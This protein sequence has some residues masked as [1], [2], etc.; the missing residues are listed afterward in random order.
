VEQQAGIADEL[1]EE[2]VRHLERRG[3]GSYTMRSYR[4]GL[5]DFS[6]WLTRVGRELVEVSRRDVEAY[7]GEFAAGPGTAARGSGVVD[8]ATGQPVRVRR[9]ARTVNHRLSVLASFFAFLL[10]RDTELGGVWAGRVSPVPARAGELTHSMGGGGDAPPWRP[11][12]ELRRRE[13]RE[14]PAVLDHVEVDRLVAAARSWRDKALLVLLSRSGQRIGDWSVEHGRHG[15]LGMGLGDLDRRTSTIVVRLKGAR[16]EHRVPTTGEFWRFFDRYLE[17]ERRDAPGEA[18]WVGLRRGWPRP[19]TYG[20]FEAALRQLAARTGIEVTAHMFRHTV[21]SE[22][23]A[24]SGV[25]AAQELLGHRHIATTVDTYAHVDPQALVD[26]VTGVER[27][28]RATIEAARR[29]TATGKPVGGAQYVF[30]YD[31]QTLIELDAVA[32]PRPAAGVPESAEQ[33]K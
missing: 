15:V 29:E 1:V 18:A 17:H 12:A 31:S 6:R 21:A 19:L 16:D 2:F 32:T 25:V 20:A 7:V 33:A 9:E 24:T 4:L 13:P 30:D 11:R 3:R 28:A 23:V 26:A 14:L 22:V 27:Q 5:G 10:D 8:L